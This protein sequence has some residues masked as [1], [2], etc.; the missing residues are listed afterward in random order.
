MKEYKLSGYI[1]ML[2]SLIISIVSGYCT[3]VGMGKVFAS[4]AYVT[5]FIATV[6]EMGRV[7]LIY[8]LHHYWDKMKFH[9]KVPGVLMLLIAIILSAMGIFGFMSNAHTQR[10]QEVVPIELEIKQKQSEINV[11]N[12]SI[13]INNQQLE[14][15]DGKAF[16]KYTEMGYVTKAVNLQKEQQKITDKIY[17]DNRELQQ[18][19]TKLNQEILQLQLN[20]EQKAPTLAHL[21]YYAKLFNVSNDMA[22]IIFIVMIM[23]VFDT[24]AMYLMI[25]SD[26][27]LKLSM[28][29]EEDELKP[30]LE[31]QTYDTIYES[32]NGINEKINQM[33]KDDQ[34]FDEFKEKIDSLLNQEKIDSELLGDYL[35]TTI[36]KINDYNVSMTTDIMTK[37]LSISTQIET[38]RDKMLSANDI[39][40][41]YERIEKMINVLSFQVSNLKDTSLVDKLEKIENDIKKIYEDNSNKKE[42]LKKNYEKNIDRRVNKLIELIENDNSILQTNEFQKYMREN[43]FLLNKLKNYFQ[44]NEIIK[45]YLDNL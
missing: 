7:V 41:I 8:D 34:K 42:E 27:I 22:I 25:T 40:E 12:E 38:I 18:K 28:K 44:D 9:Q 16:D 6:I 19:I 37:M 33:K 21:K 3:V 4:A 32:L 36:Q 35:D 31:K 26:W 10:T 29:K 1:T 13:E 17:D 24:L 5:M 14:Q 11:L 2:V 45:Q 20:A 39:E 43:S 23:T 30:I 15:F